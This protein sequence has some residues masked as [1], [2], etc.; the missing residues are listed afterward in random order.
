[1]F[2]WFNNLRMGT[3]LLGA[4]LVLV[5]L[6]GGV[7]GGLGYFNLNSVNNIIN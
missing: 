5:L 1:M 2:K 4:C 7:L 6:V 3:K